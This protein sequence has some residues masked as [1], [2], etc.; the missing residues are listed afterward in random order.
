M[1]RERLINIPNG[2]TLGRMALTGGF[3]VV[4]FIHP[5]NRLL[6]AALFLLAGST[7]FLDGMLARELGQVTWLGKMLDPLADKLLALAALICLVDLKALPVW[8]VGWV[9]V[10]E[11]YLMLGSMAL[12]RRGIVVS[13][14][15][16]GKLSTALF[17]PAVAL[18]YPWHG[19]RALAAV[20]EM[21]LYVSL[22]VS[23][24]ATVHYSWV[25][26]KKSHGFKTN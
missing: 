6:A 26:V 15:F 16:M 11:A 2:I 7:D 22:I 8:L 12:L 21:M 25:A 10:K 24:S 14:D 13:S 1:E 23:V 19:E 20:G 4:H 17:I 3:M 18:I 5:Q 9:I